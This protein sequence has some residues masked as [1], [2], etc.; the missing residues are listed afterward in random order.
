MAEKWARVTL[1]S[2]KWLV[3][4][5]CPDKENEGEI[6]HT[7]EANCAKVA[8]QRRGDRETHEAAA[9]QRRNSGFDPRRQFNGT[10]PK[11]ATPPQRPRI[12]TA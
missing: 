9:R 5:T 1:Q 3:D 4:R 2:D 10:P 12:D 7:T 8:A 6:P 11:G